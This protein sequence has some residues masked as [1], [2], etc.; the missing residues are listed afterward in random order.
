MQVFKRELTI[1]PETIEQRTTQVLQVNNN[2]IG[3]YTLVPQDADTVELEHLFVDPSYLRQGFGS[4][5]FKHARVTASSLD[6]RRIVIQSDPNAEGFYVA[7]GA[8]V[9]ELIPSSIPGRIL[10]LLELVL[11]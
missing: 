10:P 3:Y 11:K 6:F 9:I 1:L 4:Q 8:R 7:H 5:L 2:L